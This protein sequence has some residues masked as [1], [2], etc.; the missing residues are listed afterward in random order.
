MKMEKSAKIRMSQKEVNR[1]LIRN[2]HVQ[3]RYIA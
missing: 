3:I 2:S 1:R